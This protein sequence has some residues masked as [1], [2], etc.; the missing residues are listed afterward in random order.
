MIRAI[1]Q[2]I[3]HIELNLHVVTN[4]T[5]CTGPIKHNN[6]E[7]IIVNDDDKVKFSKFINLEITQINVFDLV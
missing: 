7:V 2:D 1:T 5:I 6:H 3:E 4:N